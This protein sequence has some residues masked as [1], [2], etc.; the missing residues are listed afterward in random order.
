MTDRQLQRQVSTALQKQPE[1]RD[2]RFDVKDGFAALFAECLTT[3]L[4]KSLSEAL[5][6]ISGAKAIII[7]TGADNLQPKGLWLRIIDALQRNNEFI[8][9]GIL[10]EVSNGLVYL[11]GSVRR[12]SQRMLIGK[13]IWEVKVI[14]GICNLL[15]VDQ[16]KRKQVTT[17]RYTKRTL[18][19]CSVLAL[20][21]SACTGRA[22]TNPRSERA[23][24][25]D[26]PMT[27]AGAPGPLFTGKQVPV[28]CYHQVREWTTGDS[29]SARSYII[30]PG[31]FGEH[32]KMLRDSGYQVI[33]PDRL[34][35]YLLG[36][37]TLPPKPVLLTFDDGTVSQYSNALPLLSSQGFTAVFF[38][39]T[40]T[41]N[42]PGYLTRQQ[43][44][45]LSNLGYTIGCHSWDHHDVRH[46]TA[47]DW[48]V[49]LVKP[50]EDLERITGRPVRH[51]AYPFGA[52]NAAAFPQLR[53]NG[54][55]TAF[56]LSSKQDSEAPLYT[57][58]RIIADGRWT[59]REL[60][61]AIKNSFR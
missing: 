19:L 45:E 6:H 13:I 20:F 18:I 16:K 56:Q 52:W 46:Y 22:N 47:K 59:P 32:L 21:I 2:I 15:K 48:S 31:R 50:T 44:K 42:R 7:E 58:R 61:H 34:V 29:K 1:L 36:K 24:K 33:E 17:T 5:S 30:P 26:R 27:E 9:E 14:S 23:L 37:T 8:A 10:I 28:L 35:N 53:K 3:P 39:M 25:A 60:D 41:L 49:Q 40:V 38:I 4:K 54:Y 55:I 51:F 12:P 57:I 43:I 11:E